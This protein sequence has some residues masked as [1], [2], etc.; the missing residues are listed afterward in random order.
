MARKISSI[1]YALAMGEKLNASLEENPDMPWT[2]HVEK[3]E[4]AVRKEESQ[5]KA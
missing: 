1:A 4:E 3:A 2:E 5:K